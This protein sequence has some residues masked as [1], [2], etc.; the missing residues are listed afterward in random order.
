MVKNS[1][2][3]S[4]ILLSIFILILSSAPMTNAL[5]TKNNK[6]IDEEPW[7]GYTLFAPEYSTVTYLIDMNENVI[8]TWES[9][10]IQGLAAYLLEDGSIIRSCLPYG[11][12]T[13]MGGG[14]TGR[15]EI[16]SWD[17]ELLWGFDYSNDQVCMHH[18]LEVL[19]N[20]NVL[21]IAWEY[22]TKAQAVTAGRNPSNIAFNKFFPD[23]IIEVKP[24]GPA[25][26]EIVW[27]W[28]AWDHLIQDFDYTKNNYGVV[29]D[30]P[31]LIDINYFIGSPDWMHTNSI[32]YNEEFDQIMISLHN[33]DEIWVIDHSTTT[34]EAK[35]HTGG[36][37]GMG[38]DLLYRW[39]N[40]QTYRA[41]NTNDKK[42]FGQHDAQWIKS[43]C[44]GE[45]NILVF[46][47]GWNRPG[48]QYSTVDEFI[49]PVDENG[50]Y[51][52]DAESP[53]DPEEQI[54]IYSKEVPNDFVALG[55]SGASRLP[56]GNTL[57]CNGP[58]GYFFE[59]TPE[60][61]TVWDYTNPYPNLILNAVF[62]IQRYSEDYPGLDN[63]DFNPEKPETPYGPTSGVYGIEYT[64]YSSTTDPQEDKIFYWFNWGDG[65]NSVWLGPYDSG[66]IISASHIW[67]Q[68]GVYNIKV[69]ARDLSDH[70]SVWSDSF[71]ISLPRNKLI[72]RPLLQFFQ[73]HPALS[74]LDSILKF[75]FLNYN[76]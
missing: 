52:K 20:G 55:I 28:H 58:N 68:S 1:I 34:Y 50:D 6:S 62:K 47:N 30:H 63:L 7:D 64:F 17:G 75:I 19:P 38:G 65:S 70:E 29:T 37:S 73:N 74:L 27:Q 54:W 13:F 49:P 5:I 23:Q 36:N 21:M 24:T 15:V 48:G 57:I 26:G 18:D 2:N 35:G 3:Y 44:P 60:K 8:H 59:V 71:T 72:N 32:D 42:L 9:N 43:G 45:G 41:G 67:S 53:Y 14:I 25:S 4:I 40:P 11:N 33:F 22:K 46:N 51:H 76:K 16:I 56:N 39:G 10:Y 12:P 31:E 66:E 61:D 69:K